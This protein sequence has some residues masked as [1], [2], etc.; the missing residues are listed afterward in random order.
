MEKTFDVE[1]VAKVSIIYRGGLLACN[2]PFK[3]VMTER[4]INSFRPFVEGL[5]YTEIQDEKEVVAEV[6]PETPKSEPIVENIEP[7]EEITNVVQQ[8]RYDRPNKAKYKG[9]V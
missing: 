4:E 1:G 3:V 8:K 9:R 2:K 6:V 7:K 5:R